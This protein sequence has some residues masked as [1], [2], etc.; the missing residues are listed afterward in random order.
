VRFLKKLLQFSGIEEDRLKAGWIS[1]AEAPEF[2]EEV[3]SF[4]D[5][6]RT[7]GPSPL[8]KHHNDQRAA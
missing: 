8:R 1:S 6:L 3:R 7:I 4:I 2:V 5:K